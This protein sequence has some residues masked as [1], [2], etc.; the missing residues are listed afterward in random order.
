[1]L[2]WDTLGALGMG[3]LRIPWKPAHQQIYV[4]GNPE[5]FCGVRSSDVIACPPV[6]SMARNGRVH[7]F[8]KPVELLVTLLKKMRGETVLDPFMGSGSTGV[9]CARLGRKFI[10]IEIDKG[11]FDIA[12]KRIERAYADQALFTGGIA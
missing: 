5:G 11:Y 6:Q 9:A 10:G 1:M 7:P 12:C 8:E 3:D 2:V 4:L